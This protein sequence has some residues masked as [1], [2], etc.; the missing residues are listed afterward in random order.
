M[1]ALDQG[2]SFDFI[3]GEMWEKSPF[4]VW[5]FI[6]QRKRWL[7][8]ILLVVHSRAV[9]LRTKWLLGVACYSW[10]VLPLVTSK[11]LLAAFFPLPCPAAMNALFA[12][13]EGMNL[14][15]YIF[16]VLKSFSVYRFGVLRFFLCIC[17]TLLIIPFTLVI[18]NIAVIWGVFGRKHKF[19]IVNKEFHHSPVIIA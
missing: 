10:V 3:E 11:V 19:Y 15:M 16:G 18:E 4:S 14:Y 2:Y 7:Q 6:Q 5:D 8:G 9:P 17:G 13:V 12:F 1:R